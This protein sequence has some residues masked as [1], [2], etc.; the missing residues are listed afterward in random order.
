M[1]AMHEPGGA[2]SAA[3][4][5]G[6]E[7]GASARRWLGRRPRWALAAGAVLVLLLVGLGVRGLAGAQDAAAQPEQV[8]ARYCSALLTRDYAA[9]AA[10]LAPAARAGET[11]QQYVADEQVRETVD[12]RVTAC[13][14]GSAVGGPFGAVGFALS[15]PH[16]ASV[17]LTLTRA[18]LGATSGTVTLARTGT[19]TGWSVAGVSAPLLGTN[20]T[21]L[22]TASGFCA[23]LA[24]GNYAG[25]YADLSAHQQQLEKSVKQFTSEATQPAGAAFTGCTPNYASYAL[26]GATA[27]LTLTIN[28]R[29]DMTSGTP[30]I[31]IAATMTL[32]RQGAAWKVDGLDLLAQA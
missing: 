9:E 12:G 20:L 15:S 14:A 22:H 23:A 1:S 13:H 2:G 17:P 18:K 25:A 8:A 6:K 24:A 27:T 3:T 16:Q 19:G 29:V 21:P 4:S 5:G 11:T 30:T 31:P 26:K 32:V 28:V 10:L 7:L